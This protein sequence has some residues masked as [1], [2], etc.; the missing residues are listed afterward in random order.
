MTT[1]STTGVHTL[2]A[3]LDRV[4]QTGADRWLACCPAHDDKSP[5]LSIREVSDGRLLI[6]CW[7]NCSPADVMANVGLSLADLFPQRHRDQYQKPMRSG[8]RWVPRDALSAVARE[9]LIV[10]HAADQLCQGIPLDDRDVSRV[11][12]AAGRVRNAAREVGC[13]V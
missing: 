11:A 5:S 12:V 4:T 6:H 10:L 9:M 2:L 1:S 13:Y 8:E 3:R 7:A